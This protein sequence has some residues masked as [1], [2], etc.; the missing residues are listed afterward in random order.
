MTAVYAAALIS[1]LMLAAFFSYYVFRLSTSAGR[2]D[3]DFDRRLSSLIGPRSDMASVAMGLPGEATSRTL[4][5]PA[6]GL[7]GISPDPVF[8]RRERNG[9]V[10]FQI[11]GRPSMPLRYLLDGRSRAR[12]EQVVALADKELGASWALLARED[13]QDRLLLTPL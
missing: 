3:S 6:L 11:E 12:L 13:S 2:Q 10:F 5:C 1:A 7:R 4:E 9:Q 8:L